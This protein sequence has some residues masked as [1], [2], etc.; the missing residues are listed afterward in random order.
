MPMAEAILAAVDTRSKREDHHRTK[1]GSLF[2]KWKV[3]FKLQN[4][5]SPLFTS[6]LAFN[7]TQTTDLTKLPFSVLIGPDDWKDYSVGKEGVARYRDNRG[8]LDPNND[9][10]VYL[11]V[12]DNVRRR[13]QQYGRTGDHLGSG[14]SGEKASG[15]FEDM[16]SRGFSIA[17]RWAPMKS[18]ADAQRM[19]A[20]RLKTY[21]Y[22][23]NKVSNGPRRHD[24]ILEKLDKCASNCTTQAIFSRKHPPFLQKQLGIKIKASKLLSHDNQF[25]KYADGESYNFLSP[26][27]KF[28]RSQPRLVLDHGGS[29][30]NDTITC[31]LLLGD[32]SICRKP[33]VEGRKM[34]AE[35]K[36]KETK[37]SSMRLSTSEKSQLQKAYT[38][39]V[40]LDNGDFNVHGAKTPS[41]GLVPLLAGGN[42]EIEQCSPICGVAMDDGSLCRRQP[43]SGRQRCDL[44][45]GRKICSSNSKRVPYV[46]FDSDADEDSGFYK[47][48]SEL[49]IPGKVET[50]VAP[51]RPVFSKGYDT[52][53][54]VELGNGYFCTKQPGRGR[55]RC[56][57]HKGMRVNSL[58]SGLDRESTLD[59]SDTGSRFNPHNWNYG[60]SSSSKS[61]CGAT[62]CNG[63]FCQR[64]VKGNDRCEQHLD[65][66][67]RSSSSNSGARYSNHGG[68][69]SSICGAPTHNG[70]SC[71]RTVMGNGRCFQHLNYDGG[72]SSS[73]SSSSNFSSRYLNYGGCSTSICGAPTCNGS[74]CQRTVKGNG[75]CF[76]HLNYGDSSSSSSNFS[77]PY[78]YYGGCSTSICG[79]P[80]RNGSFCRRTVKG[81]G[82]CWQH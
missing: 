70:S 52:I 41:F 80:T 28:S 17:Y 82:R 57:D 37:G 35:H 29:N 24:D 47:R 10:V 7:D 15:F 20:G 67:G 81:N 16:F 68:S 72:S 74:F 30:E 25:S 62:T 3:P 33:P 34:C 56:E 13:L 8:K 36:G 38:E 54:G 45:K 73:S 12:A 64:T 5:L 39:H 23:W 55:D 6:K 76:Q 21:D 58:F 11:G 65:Y 61:I 46:V 26:V 42:P 32:D 2:S 40:V 43:V 27:F 53:C 44:H 63:S 75:R 49:F 66:G 77:S 79:A 59:V 51:Q 1:D 14:G 69:S 71:Q 78:S 4:L 19:E 22:A 60:S 18:T 50:G 48:S 9:V 31:G